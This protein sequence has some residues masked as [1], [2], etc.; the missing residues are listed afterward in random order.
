MA[1]WICDE[2][3]TAYAVDAPRCPHCGST[4]YHPDSVPRDAEQTVTASGSG[5]DD[6][7]NTSDK[8]ATP[9]KATGK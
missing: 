6:S 9:R 4:E 5:D 8:K 2:C 1:L 3:T 7:E